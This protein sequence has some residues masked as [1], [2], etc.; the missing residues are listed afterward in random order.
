MIHFVRSVSKGPCGV[1]LAIV[2]HAGTACNSVCG[3][4]DPTKTGSWGAPSRAYPS[5]L[6]HCVVGGGDLVQATPITAAITAAL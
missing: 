6:T 2:D 3:D 4:L 1:R 5:Y